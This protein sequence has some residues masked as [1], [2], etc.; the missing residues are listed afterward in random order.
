MDSESGNISPLETLLASLGGCMGVYVRLF[1]KRSGM[2]EGG[3]TIN[4]SA[5]LSKEKPS[6]FN[7]IKAEVVISGRELTEEQKDKLLKYVRSCP[8]H[9]T[10]TSGPEI[11]ISVKRQ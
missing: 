7:I 8:V 5:D 3:F 2:E 6:Q 4:L 1:Q 9:N 10:I 11:E